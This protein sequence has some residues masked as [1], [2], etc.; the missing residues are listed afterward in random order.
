MSK[1]LLRFLI[2]LHKLNI[3]LLLHLTFIFYHKLVKN[4]KEVSV[5]NH[6]PKCGW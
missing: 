4:K 1:G 3:S 5:K 6:H 2:I